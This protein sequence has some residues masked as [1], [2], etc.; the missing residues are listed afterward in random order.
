MTVSVFFSL[1]VAQPPRSTLFPYT[2][3]FRSECQ[4]MAIV[5]EM[6]AGDGRIAEQLADAIDHLLRAFADGS[7]G[8]NLPRSVEHTYELQ[9][10]MYLVCCLLLEKKKDPRDVSPA[11]RHLQR[12]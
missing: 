5:D 12:P 7:Y 1:M 11:P 9:S 6:I 4:R 2:T 3:L 10:P 8:C